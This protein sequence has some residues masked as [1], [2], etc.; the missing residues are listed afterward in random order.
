MA[1]DLGILMFTNISGLTFGFAVQNLGGK[2][3]YDVE[4]EKIPHIFRFGGTYKF[5]NQNLELAGDITKSAEEEFVLNLGGQYA[6][7]NQFF[8]RLGNRF[9]DGKLLTP[10]F[11]LGFL[12]QNKYSLDYGFNYFEELGAVH[13]LAFSFKLYIPY[14]KTRK[15]PTNLDQ[16]LALLVPPSKVMYEIS[17]NRLVISWTEVFNAQY[18]VYGRADHSKKWI[19]L[20]KHLLNKTSMELK[21]GNSGKSLYVTV[22]AVKKGNESRYA[23]EVRV[24]EN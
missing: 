4:K 8:L 3:M 7:Q 5:P 22:T 19:K 13:Q 16:K 17:D 1:F 20:N 6:F 14:I 21:F 24:N 23:R 15:S 2:I 10:S 9:Q 12:L 11:G 18:N